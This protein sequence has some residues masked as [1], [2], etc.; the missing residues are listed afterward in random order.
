MTDIKTTGQLRALLTEMIVEV[1]GDDSNPNKVNEA[2]TLAQAVT[3]S[4]ACEARISEIQKQQGVESYA[5]GEL[6]IG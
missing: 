5:I 3:D 6:P 1:K 2:T 4:L